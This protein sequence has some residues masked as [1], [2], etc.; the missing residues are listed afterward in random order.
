MSK[1]RLLKQKE[2]LEIAYK[3][4][5]RVSMSSEDHPDIKSWNVGGK[6]KLPHMTVVQKSARSRD[7]GHVEAEFE[8]EKVHGGTEE[9][10]EKEKRKD[11]G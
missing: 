7:D 10:G 4:K 8:I 2:A 1:E 9:K 11:Y 3:P 6:Y 5:A